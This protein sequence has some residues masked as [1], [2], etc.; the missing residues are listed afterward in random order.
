MPVPGYGF[1]AAWTTEIH[2]LYM[3]MMK[4]DSK[5]S[6]FSRAELCKVMR[7]VLEVAGPQEGVMTTDE[8][9]ADLE[10]AKDEGILKL[11]GDLTLDKMGSKDLLPNDKPVTEGQ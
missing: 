3:A 5:A 2:D 7:A 8:I 6:D 1:H 10:K 11:I 9:M 4:K